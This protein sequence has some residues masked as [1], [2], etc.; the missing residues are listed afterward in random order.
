MTA[1]KNA[2]WAAGFPERED[3]VVADV[4][5]TTGY[6]LLPTIFARSVD[7]RVHRV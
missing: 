1:F 2:L 6:Q 4:L 7:G 5:D 3:I